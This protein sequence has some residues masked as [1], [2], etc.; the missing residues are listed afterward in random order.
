M[1]EKA[2][3]PTNFERILPHYPFN[4]IASMDKYPVEMRENDEELDVKK[5]MLILQ[6][7]EKQIINM[8]VPVPFDPED[9]GF[10]DIGSLEEP[11]WTVEKDGFRFTMYPTSIP[12]TWYLEKSYPDDE[13]VVF[14]INELYIPN[15]IIAQVV[16]RS[17]GVIP[18][19]DAHKPMEIVHPTHCQITFKLK[20]KEANTFTYRGQP[21][22][23]EPGKDI[24]ISITAEEADSGIDGN[25]WNP[26]EIDA[27]TIRTKW[28]AD[29][30]TSSDPNQNSAA[31]PDPKE[32][33]A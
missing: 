26:Q 21:Y 2:Y 25:V 23:C 9:Y 13:Y 15:D 33:E 24:S 31:S 8:V 10:K 14:V 22:P 4:V 16:L 28:Y 1:S 29:N 30:E 11:Y 20:D 27:E 5:A 32:E 19:L 17:L 7:A 18:M 6:A 12:G 3:N